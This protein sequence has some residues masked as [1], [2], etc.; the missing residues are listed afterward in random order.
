MTETGLSEGKGG[1]AFKPKIPAQSAYRA[2]RDD[3]GEHALT[4]RTY[5][6]GTRAPGRPRWER[7][8]QCEGAQGQGVDAGGAV[9]RASGTSGTDEEER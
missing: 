7:F 8:A 1:H 9:M 4:R 2:L 5:P 3:L 6:S